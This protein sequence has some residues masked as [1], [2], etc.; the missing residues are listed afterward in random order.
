MEPP[1]QPLRN[2]RDRMMDGNDYAIGLVIVE[3]VLYIK[4]V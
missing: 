2:S 4:M 1:V 3:L